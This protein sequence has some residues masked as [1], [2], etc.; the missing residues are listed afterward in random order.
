MAER[1]TLPNLDGLEGNEADDFVWH[2]SNIE[3][4]LNIGIQN[5]ARY[6]TILKFF[7]VIS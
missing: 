4:H 5:V 1:T 6:G 3:P 2:V 7:N